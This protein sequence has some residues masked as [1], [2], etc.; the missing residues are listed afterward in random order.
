MFTNTKSPATHR[1]Y[2]ANL[3]KKIAHSQKQIRE[4]MKATGSTVVHRTQAVN[5][6]RPYHT[7][8]EEQII[9]EEILAEQIKLWQY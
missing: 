7:L 9:R 2:R 5:V 4:K 6:K 1:V 3:K 8:E